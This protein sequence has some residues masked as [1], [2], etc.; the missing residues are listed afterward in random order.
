VA[1]LL[2]LGAYHLHLGSP[3]LWGDEADTANFARSVL[4]TGLP[5]ALLG[6]NALAYGDCY[7]L[8][9][10]LLSRQLPWVQYYVGAASIALFG[11]DAAGVRR[12]F[13]LFGALSFLPLWWALRPRTRAAPAL[14]ALVLLVPQTLLFQ[15]QAR[16]YPIVLL[17]ASGLA[18]VLFGELRS[19]RR[20]FF[21]ALP[22]ALLLFHA[23]PV[24]ALGTCG[25]ACLFAQRA[26]RD[27]ARELIVASCIGGFSWLIFYLALRPIPSAMESPLDLL[28]QNPGGWLGRTFTGF[29]AGLADLDYVGCLPLLPWLVLAGAALARR[30]TAH[31]L[32]AAKSGIGGFVLLLLV[33]QVLLAAAVVGVE[34]RSSFAVLRYLPHAVALA[35]IPLYLVLEAELRARPPPWSSCSGSASSRSRVGSASFRD[36]RRPSLGG[37]R[38]MGRSS[39]RRRTTCGA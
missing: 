29:A 11:D 3:S 12:L 37:P 6:E 21:V 28:S 18:W 10:P 39:L 20:R 13:A 26:A 24:A 7:Q 4:R 27:R 17:L 14:A 19:R 8:G 35:P 34:T 31:A 15:R 25:A 2:V 16:Y 38:P 22:C 23:H 32:R 9:G 5:R 33:F 1:F 30:R 36:A